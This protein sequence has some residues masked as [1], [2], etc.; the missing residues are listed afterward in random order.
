MVTGL[1]GA[2]LLLDSALRVVMAFTLP[3]DLVPVLSVVLIVVTPALAKVLGKAYG[4][5]I[6]LTSPRTADV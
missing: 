6:G 5:R 3:V 2:G 1:W 4:R